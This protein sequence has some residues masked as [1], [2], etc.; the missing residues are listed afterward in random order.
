MDARDTFDIILLVL[1]TIALYVEFFGTSTGGAGTIQDVVDALAN[2][3]PIFYLIIGGVLGVVFVSYIT[4]Y[5]PQ[6]HSQNASRR[7]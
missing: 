2:V 6:K 4:I 5:L 3:D 7:S 1:V